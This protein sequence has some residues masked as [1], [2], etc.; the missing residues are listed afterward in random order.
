MGDQEGKGRKESKEESGREI[1]TAIMCTLSNEQA[2]NNHV[3]PPDSI[4]GA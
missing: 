2:R 1:L 3:S 4:Y